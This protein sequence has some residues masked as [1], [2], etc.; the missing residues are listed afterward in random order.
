MLA[1]AAALALPPCCC[2]AGVGCTAAMMSKRSLGLL[3]IA[4]LCG[5][6]GEDCRVYALKRF[7][8]Q[9]VLRLRPRQSCE[10]GEEEGVGGEDGARQA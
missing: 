7:V 5:P 4:R 9:T 8:G 10:S 6:V 2:I 3:P 1:C